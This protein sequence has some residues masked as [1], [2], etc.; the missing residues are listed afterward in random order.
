MTAIKTILAAAAIAAVASADAKTAVVQKLPGGDVKLIPGGTT[1]VVAPSATPVAKFAAEELSDYLSRVLGA[2]V[3]VAAAPAKDG[4]SV[5]VGDSEWARAAGIDAPATSQDAYRIRAEGNK[6]FIAGRDDPK[7]NPASYIRGKSARSF[8]RGTLNG[9]YGFL[10]D[11]AGVGFFFIGELGTVVPRAAEVKVPCGD[12]LVSPDFL[13]RNWSYHSMGEPYEGL[14]KAAGGKEADREWS[15]LK[16]RNVLHLRMGI[17]NISGACH[18]LRAFRVTRRFAKD[19]PEFF[20][21]NKDGSRY[22]YDTEKV[23][24]SKNGKLCFSNPGLR[25]EIYKD[26]KAYLTGQPPSSRGLDV[27]GSMGFKEGGYVCIG[28]EDGYSE[29]LCPGCQAMYDRTKKSWE[30]KL[31]WDFFCDMAARLKADGIDGK[32]I[33]AKGG[34][35]ADFPEIKVPDNVVTRA[36]VT[37]PWAI[38]R[39]AETAAALERIKK[40]MN[41]SGNKVPL[42][43][44]AGK[45]RCLQLDIPDIP[46]LTPRAHIEFY[47]LAAPYLLGSYDESS[48][49]RYLFEA[50]NHYAYAH[51]CWDTTIDP[52]KFM[53]AAYA[54]LFGAGA[55]AMEKFF[56]ALEDLWLER[57]CGKRVQTSIGP[58]NKSPSPYELWTS[59]YSPAF[60]AEAKAWLKEAFGAVARGSDEAKRIAIFKREI[61]DRLAKASATYFE[62]LDPAV[63]LARRAKVKPVNLIANAD[64]FSKWRRVGYADSVKMD[65]AE[66]FDGRPTLSISLS[67]DQVEHPSTY[68]KTSVSLKPGRRYRFSYFVKGDG[69]KGVDKRPGAGGCVWSGV[70]GARSKDEKTFA[71]CPKPYL[72][73]DFGWSHYFMEF[74]TPEDY[75]EHASPTVTLRLIYAIGSVHFAAPLVEEVPRIDDAP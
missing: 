42:W 1:V 69:I 53:S 58:V 65:K 24:H 60:L 13:E 15:S 50:L 49:D 72:D 17:Q 6:V 36:A 31:I 46:D 43:T 37:G 61:F 5:F 21:L 71:N 30:G 48:T 57:V 56:R 23:P 29:C 52:D 32:I 67:P 18:G 3:P 40:V 41:R 34:A 22:L 39:P 27:W 47:R 70:K 54:K 45:F 55:P 68:A 12:I 26:I 35:L 8:H 66:L 11:Y 16:H 2:K 7:V 38:R 75:P 44:Y 19:H 59:I 63:E 9:V 14:L 25:D 4:V 33:C 10:E 28:P 74:D 62:K 73:G 64:D 20:K 51:V